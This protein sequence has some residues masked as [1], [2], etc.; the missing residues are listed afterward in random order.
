MTGIDIGTGASCIYPLI[1]VTQR[2]SW[3]FIGTDI[4]AKSL[5]YA[6]R[7]VEL[8]G[9]QDRIRIVA[10]NRDD[11]HLLPLDDVDLDK[12]D[13]VMCNPPFY[14]SDEDM[15]NSAEKKARPPNSVC[16]GAPVEMVC[17]GG[18]VTFTT[19]LLEDSLHFRERVQWYTTMFGKLT[20]LQEFVGKLREKGIDNYA[21]TEFVQGNKTKRWAVGW[22]FG[23]MR[24]S[25]EAAR[26]VKGALWKGLLPPVVE[27][28][29]GKANLKDGVRPL[30]E[31]LSV[32]VGG[33]ELMEWN[34]DKEKLRGVGRAREN[35]WSRAWRRRKMRE[36]KEG[37]ANGA[38]DVK[39]DGECEFGFLVSARVSNTEAT[40]NLRW[41]EGH[42]NG[43]FES[44][45]GWLK[46]QMKS[47]L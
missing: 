22:S 1:G 34:W 29:I 45:A 15:V 46:T 17:E 14:T 4:D 30:E 12:V 42:D 19:R 13:F 25:D 40:I 7:N 41:L 5:V 37:K 31:R 6:R 27:V 10:K 39:S 18:E 20:S 47:F 23:S 2:P 8:N 35:V 9:L 32:V 44:F 24:P 38:E 21:V 33:L 16:T 26:G 28:E 36:E 43:L 3:Y 11:A